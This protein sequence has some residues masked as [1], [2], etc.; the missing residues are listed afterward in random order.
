[1]TWKKNHSEAGR[2]Q[3]QAL[4]QIKQEIAH[5]G[6]LEPVQTGPAMQNILCTAAGEQ[7]PTWSLWQRTALE[8]DHWNFGAGLIEDQKATLLQQKKRC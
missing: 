3:Q 7:G 1:M 4:E 5:A 8:E 2:E 6:A